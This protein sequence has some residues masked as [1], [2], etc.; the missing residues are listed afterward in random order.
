[1]QYRH[2]KKKRSMWNT[3]PTLKMIP[4]SIVLSK[5]NVRYGLVKLP[6]LLRTYSHKY[7][8]VAMIQ[9]YHSF[10]LFRTSHGKWKQTERIIS[11]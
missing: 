1:M 2:F 11:M 6:Y 9:W 8:E 4:N 10:V 5:N 3:S 7:S